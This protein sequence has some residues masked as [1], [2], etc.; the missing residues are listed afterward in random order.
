MHS[1]LPVPMHGELKPCQLHV[2]IRGP[3]RNKTQG[4]PPEVFRMHCIQVETKEQRSNKNFGPQSKPCMF[5]GYVHKTTKVWRLWDFEQKK[6]V[7]YSYVVWREDQ[8][9]FDANMDDAEAFI[10]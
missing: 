5:L 1:L 10:W 8:N 7:E 4:T 9:V 3:D 2:T 6:A